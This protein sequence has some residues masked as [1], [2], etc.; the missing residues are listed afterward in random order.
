MM[1]ANQIMQLHP[2]KSL[3]KTQVQSS[4]EAPGDLSLK[5]A[6]ARTYQELMEISKKIAYSSHE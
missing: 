6:Q 3:L 2:S 4:S 5:L 1:A